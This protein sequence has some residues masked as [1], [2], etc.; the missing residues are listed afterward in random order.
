M[1]HRRYRL[2][3]RI[4]NIVKLKIQEN[5]DFQLL[6]TRQNF[7]PSSQVELQAHFKCPN[8]TF[9][10]MRPLQRLFGRIHV[11]GEDQL[12]GNHP[13]YLIGISHP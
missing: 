2:S 13:H 7:A 10:A 8:P 4:R 3:H 5:R 1:C 11:Q 12:I 9:E 6:Q